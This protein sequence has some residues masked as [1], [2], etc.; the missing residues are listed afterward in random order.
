MSVVPNVSILMTGA[1]GGHLASA[2]S[3][4]EAFEGRARVTLVNVLDEHAPFPFNRL[5]ASYASV[6]TIAPQLY[7]LA[8]EVIQTPIGGRLMEGGTYEYVRADIARSITTTRPD[9]VLSVHA[10]LNAIPLR[11]IREVGCSAPFVSVVVDAGVPPVSWFTAKADLCCV[12]DEGIRRLALDA[13][14][15]PEKVVSTGLPIRRSFL[16]ARRLSK[17][18]A[19][20]S[21]GLD[22]HT[23]LVLIAG[24]GAGLGRVGAVATAIAKHL[25]QTRT[26]AQIAVIAGGNRALR[27]RLERRDWP[28]PVTV[29]GLTSHMAELMAAADVLLTKA[30]PGTIAEA[31]CLGVPTLLTGFVPGQEAENVG[32]AQR[33][34][35][36]PF[37]PVPKRAA[38]LVDAWLQPGNDDLARMSERMRSMS[39]PEA[40]AAIADVSLSLLEGSRTS[41]TR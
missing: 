3:L 41:R 10:L 17:E 33:N 21:L 31:A 5:S 7:R 4:V 13:G 29:L 8:Y 37:E 22:P 35:G 16:D 25:S 32:W 36:A 24:G 40:A 27:R 39:R 28:I 18:E 34:G 30:G 9:L 23:P 26:E 2:Q 19:R 12:A 6:V 15:P 38:L 1:G 20:L 11:A 14:M